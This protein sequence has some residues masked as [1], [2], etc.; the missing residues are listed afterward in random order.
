MYHFGVKVLCGARAVVAGLWYQALQAL[1]PPLSPS[2]P[3][4]LYQ[5]DTVVL[6]K[7]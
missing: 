2:R 4:D 6:Q 3:F 1:T 7:L 5:C